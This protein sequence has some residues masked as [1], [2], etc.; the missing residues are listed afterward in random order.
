M[1][2]L[3]IDIQ[4]S[5]KVLGITPEAFQAFAEREQ[6]EGVLKLREGWRVSIFTLARL[7]NT[8]P[9]TLLEFLEDYALG[10]RMLEVADDEVLT[11]AEARAAY[12]TYRD[13]AA[14]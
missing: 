14:Q 11:A 2:Q 9:E 4:T 13:E 3:T 7:L 8:T 12:Q 1:F 10:Q 6:L 5:A